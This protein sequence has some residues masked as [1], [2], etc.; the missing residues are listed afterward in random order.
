MKLLKNQ[1]L[2]IIIALLPNLL[3]SQ[4]FTRDYTALTVPEHYYGNIYHVDSTKMVSVKNI[5]ELKHDKSLLDSFTNLVSNVTVYKMSADGELSLVGVGV[6]T[7]CENYTVIYDFSQTQTIV[8]NGNNYESFLV[9]V[10]VRMVAKF[11]S[12]KGK[13]NLSSPFGLVAN[14]DKLKGSLE[15]RVSGI[16]SQ[17]IN[18]IIPTTSDLSPSS[19]ATA[20]Q[21]VATIKSHIYD[22]ETIINPQVLAYSMVKKSLK[23]SI[24]NTN[25]KN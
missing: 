18:D 22:K 5:Q 16:G 20:L 6:S 17:K 23:E 11:T 1:T 3:F 13:I 25:E 4:D 2:I 10:S 9:G 21:A 24:K 14:I 7:K 12:L 15:V 8:I 19:I